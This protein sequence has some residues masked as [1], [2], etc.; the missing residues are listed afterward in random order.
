MATTAL[1]TSPS[2]TLPPVRV[3]LVTWGL[4]DRHAAIAE[5][6]ARSGPSRTRWT[7]TKIEQRTEDTCPIDPT[8]PK[9][10]A[11]D[12][13]EGWAYAAYAAEPSDG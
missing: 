6:V 12:A 4:T 5:D 2:R 7:F 13:R 9:V 11:A 8:D 10:I 1:C 3:R